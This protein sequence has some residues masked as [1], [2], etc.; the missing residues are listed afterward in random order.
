[1]VNEWSVYVDT[2]M[3]SNVSSKYI[4]DSTALLQTTSQH[5]GFARKMFIKS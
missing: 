1:M 2:S 5:A 3:N 4:T